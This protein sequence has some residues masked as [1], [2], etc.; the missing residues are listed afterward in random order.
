MILPGMPLFSG[1]TA[2]ALDQGV[3]S[4]PMPATSL[5]CRCWITMMG[6]TFMGNLLTVIYRFVFILAFGVAALAVAE[7]I[8]Q[9]FGQTITHGAYSAGRLFEL[10]GILATFAIALLLRDIRDDARRRQG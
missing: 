10:S 3:R 6:D 1:L 7:G 8:V 2:I 5:P 4:C 9:L